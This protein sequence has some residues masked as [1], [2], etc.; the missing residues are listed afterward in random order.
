MR[1]L[2]GRSC[3]HSNHI[4]EYIVDLLLEGSMEQAGTSPKFAP[5][6][7]RSQCRIGLRDLEALRLELADAV[8]QLGG[9][10]EVEL[11]RRL[12]H[13]VPQGV[14]QLGELVRRD[15]R[16][17]LLAP[18]RHGDVVLLPDRLPQARDA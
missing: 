5:S 11:L 3:V 7:P 6:P 16:L 18:R 13:L 15:R 9:A 8:A 1:E 14:D 17:L 4:C 2:R 12:A 10:L